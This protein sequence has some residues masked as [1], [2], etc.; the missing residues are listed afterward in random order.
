MRVNQGS[1]C[2]NH[3]VIPYD[4][5]RPGDIPGV[6]AKSHWGLPGKI[7]FTLTRLLEY[8]TAVVLV[9]WLSAAIDA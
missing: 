3:I 8:S 2:C 5:R 9:S 7:A 4:A 1:A 6:A